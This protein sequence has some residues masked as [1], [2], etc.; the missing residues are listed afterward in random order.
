MK[1]EDLPSRTVCRDRGST[2]LL[3][4][5]REDL[6]A[7]RDEIRDMRNRSFDRFMSIASLLVSLGTLAVITWRNIG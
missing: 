4:Y 2:M 6:K 1:I 3:S 5:F 7:L